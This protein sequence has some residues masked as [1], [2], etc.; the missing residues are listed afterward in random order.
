VA[1]NRE[2]PRRVV[3]HGLPHFCQKL[4]SLLHSDGWAVRY[5]PSDQLAGMAALANDLR[6]CDL[7]YTWGGRI[8]LGKF[9]WSARLMRKRKLVM[10][11]SGTDV[12]YAKKDRITKRIEHWV[13]EKTHW[14]VSPWLAEEVR[15]LGLQC[16]YVQVS[17]VQ[18]IQD[19][20]P[21]P[22][23]FSVLVYLPSLD[24]ADLYGWDQILEIARTSPNIEFVVVGVKQGETLRTPLNVKVHGWTADLTPFLKRSTVLWRPVRHDGLSFMVLEALAHGRHVL[25]S[26][27]LSGCVQVTTA[28]SARVELE[29]L[30]DLH[31]SEALALNRKGIEVIARDFSPEKVRTEILQRWDRIIASPEKPVIGRLAEPSA[32]T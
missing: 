17:F 27:P 2:M 8:D 26:Y 1:P 31:S 20:S 29:R 5:H 9:L 10:L 13:A 16:E 24:K 21:L 22:K 6:R 15:S 18:P 19:P 32:N 12:S 30:L 3:V 23:K 14:A 28:A 25:Y 4:S 11:W 7:A